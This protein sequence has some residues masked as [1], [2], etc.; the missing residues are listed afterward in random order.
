MRFFKAFPVGLNKLAA[1][2][3]VPTS[4]FAGKADEAEQAITTAI[5][6]LTRGVGGFNTRFVKI[7]SFYI[8]PFLLHFY[9]DCTQ[10]VP[11]NKGTALIRAINAFHRQSL[12]ITK[13]SASVHLWPHPLG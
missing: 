11:Y 8:H 6:K 12:L 2:A 7:S 1:V 9:L 3:V 13:P 5:S 4:V 10:D